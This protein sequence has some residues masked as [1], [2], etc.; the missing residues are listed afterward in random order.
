[1]ANHNF[2]DLTGQVFGSLT[3]LQRVGNGATGKARWLCRCEC[4][5][6]TESYGQDLR[7]GKSG[8]CQ[9]CRQA[10]LVGVAIPSTRKAAPS[11]NA[12]H[13]RIYVE[14]GQASQHVCGCGAPADEWS[15]D[16]TDPD[17]LIELRVDQKT[18]KTRPVAYSAKP[19]HY[20]PLC[21]SCHVKADMTRA[22]EIAHV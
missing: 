2:V 22:K 16:G 14:R 3:V 7:R 17:E 10:R 18:R 9:A 6:T 20:S 8:V 12:A 11:Y 4:G 19:E 21:R 15:Y 13:H 1:M 5:R